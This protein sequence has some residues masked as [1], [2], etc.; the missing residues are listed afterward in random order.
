MTARKPG[1]T[2]E[3]TPA[4]VAQRRNAAALSTG[5]RTDE[6]K[7]RC[8]RNAWKHGLTSSI[9]RGHFDNGMQSL[10]GAMGKPCKSTCEKYPCSLVEDGLTS[11]GGTCLDKQVY[12]QAFGA[13][14]DSL[15][16]GDMEGMHGLM[17]SEISAALQMLHDLRT[18]VA[19]Q[20]MVILVPMVDADGK[21]VTRENGTEVIGKAIANPGYAMMIKTLE[22]LGINLPEL[23]ATPQSKAKAK[24]AEEQTDAVQ[25]LMGGIFQRAAAA[26]GSRVIPSQLESDE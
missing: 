4:E 3:L 14:I 10:W 23:L 2:R 8:S 24:V 13:I 6:G 17:A 5:P 7:A 15:Q 26:K 1:S 25:T 22:T 20:G 9:H 11:P 18:Q 19:D 21:V 16:N 12:V